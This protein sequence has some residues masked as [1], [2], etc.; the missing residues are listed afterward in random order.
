MSP[1]LLIVV[2][3]LVLEM[4]A[5]TPSTPNV[6]HMKTLTFN[7]IPYRAK[8]TTTSSTPTTNTARTSSIPDNTASVSTSTSSRSTSTATALPIL[9]NTTSAS[10]ATVGN[11]TTATFEPSARSVISSI[12]TFDF[13]KS[14][15]PKVQAT[16]NTCS[17]KN[18]CLK[19]FC[20]RGTCVTKKCSTEI[21]CVCDPGFTGQFC[22]KNST[23]VE[24]KNGIAHGKLD[25]TPK[26]K[27]HVN[28]NIDHNLL[29]PGNGKNGNN[30]ADQNMLKSDNR[31]GN[32]DN[33][34]ENNGKGTNGNGRDKYGIH[35]QNGQDNGDNGSGHNNKENGNG[36][37]GT[38]NKNK[39]NGNK[40]SGHIKNGSGIHEGGSNKPGKE[41]INAT[42]TG[43]NKVIGGSSKTTV[44]N[45]AT[46]LTP[47]SYVKGPEVRVPSVNSAIKFDT[48]QSE[49]RKKPS[50][51]VNKQADV[52]TV[53]T[54]SVEKTRVGMTPQ[55]LAF[56]FND[57]VKSNRTKSDGKISKLKKVSKLKQKPNLPEKNII[58]TSKEKRKT[59]KKSNSKR[60]IKEKLHMLSPQE[61]KPQLEIVLTT[62]IAKG[63]QSPV[64]ETTGSVS[65][66]NNTVEANNVFANSEIKIIIETSNAGV[67]FKD[68]SVAQQN[69]DARQRELRAA[70]AGQSHINTGT[71][72]DLTNRM[73]NTLNTP[74]KEKL[75]LK[76]SKKAI[77][78]TISKTGSNT[79]MPE[80]TKENVSME[81]TTPKTTRS[82]MELTNNK[83]IGASLHSESRKSMKSDILNPFIQLMNLFG[84]EKFAEKVSAVKIEI[85][86]KQNST[87]IVNKASKDNN[88]HTTSAVEIS[89]S[90][91]QP[92]I[93]SLVSK[94]DNSS[95]AHPTDTQAADSVPL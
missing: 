19:G 3:Q 53:S 8:A 68:T 14:K 95:N 82:I 5:T 62:D 13:S 39:K 59:A 48:A 7:T 88:K 1:E 32:V 55:M 57:A 73:D 74:N 38:G 61:N 94:A 37:E 33:G 54:V 72:S 90:K 70:N 51:L 67:I 20:I 26:N 93:E 91:N 10:T 77:Q 9:G 30:N 84:S 71:D 15:S 78:T 44:D 24:K 27:H 58:D 36:H 2:L 42:G 83:A 16:V 52:V 63:K 12:R 43:I 66:L 40:N 64:A 17:T 47:G 60:T 11:T 41:S 89:E 4:S 76:T 21:S 92:R 25:A 18:M 80:P 85:I 22:D 45:Y 65:V 86:T 79:K 87:S 75:N 35:T 23:E 56:I 69:I 31:N 28:G 6:S 29:T 46:T 50:A 49:I 81:T 34:N